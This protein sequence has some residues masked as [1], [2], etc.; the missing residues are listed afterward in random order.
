M[1]N[2]DKEGLIS[3]IDGHASWFEEIADQI[4]EYA[5]LSLKEHASAALYCE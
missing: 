5:E 4:W 1:L 2:A 3:F